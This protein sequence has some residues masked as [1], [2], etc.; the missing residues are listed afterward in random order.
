MQKGYEVE[1]NAI[2]MTRATKS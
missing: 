1:S 2:D